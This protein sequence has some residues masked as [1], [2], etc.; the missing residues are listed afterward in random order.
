MPGECELLADADDLALVA[1]SLEIESLKSKA[2]VT[3]RKIDRS[4]ERS[5]LKVLREKIEAIIFDR[6]YG[7]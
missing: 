3:I 7:K 4:M 2:V 1:T 6:T 5:R